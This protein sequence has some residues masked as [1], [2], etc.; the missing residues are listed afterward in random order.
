MP[1]ARRAH[2]AIAT[3]LGLSA[4]QIDELHRTLALRV[5]EGAGT[6]AAP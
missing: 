6:G 4:A 3:E 1:R 5:P 2:A